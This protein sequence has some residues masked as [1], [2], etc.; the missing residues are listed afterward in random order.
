MK[1]L[2]AGLI[3]LVLQACAGPS[4]PPPSIDTAGLSAKVTLTAVPFHPQEL[5][6]DCGPAALA[7]MLGWTGLATDPVAVAPTV[8]TPGRQGTLQ[9]DIIQATRRADRLA[10]P[11]RGL[12]AL[13]TELDAGNP[14][15]VLQ[16]VGREHRP[17]WHYAVAMGYDLEAGSLFLHSGTEARH[18]ESF[19]DFERRWAASDRWGLT[20]TRPGHLPASVTEPDALEAAV[21][22]EQTG[23][24]EAAARVYGALLE[25]WPDNLAALMGFGN[26]RYAAGDLDT[27]SKAFR[28]AVTLHP[29]AAEAWNNLAVSL[30]DQEQLSAALE[31]AKQAA[32][33]PGPHKATAEATLAEIAA[34]GR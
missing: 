19:Q 18:A 17:Q 7:M 4:L 33:L 21:G 23:R 20:V 25:R 2:A 14:V 3:A 9:A 5:R 32:R 27:A 16:N 30:A 13:L 34:K 15:L 12:K 1:A 24:Q 8:Y 29:D 28:Q 26:A 22:L 10:M 11:V 31:A 6:D